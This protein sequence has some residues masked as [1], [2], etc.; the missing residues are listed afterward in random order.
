M[1]AVFSQFE[2]SQISSRTKAGIERYRAT[3]GH[4][5][6]KREPIDSAEI[7]RLHEQELSIREIARRLKVSEW[8]VRSRL[9]EEKGRVPGTRELPPI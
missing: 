1:L 7:V 4:W 3:E 2:R 9:R 8:T 6:R 5:G